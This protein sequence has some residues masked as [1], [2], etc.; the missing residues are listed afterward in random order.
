MEK[1]LFDLKNEDFFKFLDELFSI[2][3]SKSW[4]EIA[5]S[6]SLFKIKRTY[7]KFAELFPRKVDYLGELEKSKSTFTSIHW[8]E[9]KAN[10]IIDEVVRFSLYSDR[11]IVFHPLQNPAVTNQNMN[12]GK[13]PKYWLQDFLDSLYFYIVIQKWVNAGIVKLIINPYEYDFNLRSTID[14]QAIKRVVNSN[15]EGIFKMGLDSV[16]NDMAEK[17]AVSFRFRSKEYIINT[18]LEMQQPKFKSSEADEFAERIIAAI[19]RIN[20]LYNK[21]NIPLT[22]RML[23]VTKG[24]GPLESIMLISEKTNGNIYTPSDFHWQQINQFGVNDFWTKTNRLYSKVPLTFLN[25]VDTDFALELRKDERLLGVRTQLKKIYSELNGLSL[26]KLTDSKIRDLQE[27][28]IEEIN[29]AEAEW[30]DIKRQA[31][32]SRKKWLFGNLGAALVTNEI[33]ILPLA[34]G[35]IAWIYE[36]EKSTRQKQTIQRQRNPISVFVDLKNQK[37]NY[38]TIFKNCIF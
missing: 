35:S 16:T 32:I 1:D 11:I 20:P 27:G 23:Q 19:P 6:V 17:F 8:A 18:L 26:D 21:L 14:E 7:R 33:S 24:G 38:F 12:P 4:D 10:R 9:V 36:T 28:F 25:E 13:D 37:Q 31:E 2:N 30:Q 29:K 3:K 22:G 15:Q 34:V 5:K